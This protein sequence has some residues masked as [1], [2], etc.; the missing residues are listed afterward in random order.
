MICRYQGCSFWCHLVLTG[1]SPHDGA[2]QKVREITYNSNDL[3]L[4][5]ADSGRLHHW[6]KDIPFAAYLLASTW[7][8]R[9]SATAPRLLVL[10]I[11]SAGVCNLKILRMILLCEF[12][13]SRR[14][15]PTK[16]KDVIDEMTMQYIVAW[17]RSCIH[18]RRIE[19]GEHILFWFESV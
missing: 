4:P 9:A 14:Y 11:Q 15:L 18:S 3:T 16:D 6:V 5:L 10:H 19:E 8:S 2:N 13:R 17:H 12:Y 1:Y 7:L